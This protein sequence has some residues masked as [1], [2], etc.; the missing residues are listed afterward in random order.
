M[1]AQE[2]EV[3]YWRSYSQVFNGGKKNILL[4]QDHKLVSQV[5]VPSAIFLLYVPD[6]LCPKLESMQNLTDHLSHM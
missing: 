3:T 4:V 6:P 1:E 5:G 2:G